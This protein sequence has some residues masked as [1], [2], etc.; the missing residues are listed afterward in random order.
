MPCRRLTLKRFD[1]SEKTTAS[2]AS[3][4]RMPELI[5]DKNAVYLSSCAP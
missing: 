3:K 5:V 4:A 1:V 2:E